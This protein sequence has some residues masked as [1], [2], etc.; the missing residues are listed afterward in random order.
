MDEL[1]GGTVTI[2]V[3]NRQEERVSS[4]VIGVLLGSEEPDRSHQE[5]AHQP[6][7]KPGQNQDIRY[8]MMGN[9]R[10]AWGFGALDPGSGTAQM[11]EVAKFCLIKSL[12][13]FTCSPVGQSRSKQR[14]RKSKVARVL[15]EKGRSGW[16]PKRSIVFLSW[17]AEEYSLCGSR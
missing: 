4:N 6:T 5:C 9:H 8:V 11:M 14:D 1:N 13:P 16:R 3:N 2:E 7:S 10:D 12:K 17:G 15:G